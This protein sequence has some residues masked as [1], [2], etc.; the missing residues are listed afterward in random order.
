MMFDHH[1]TLRRSNR[2]MTTPM[3]GESNV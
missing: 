1:T 3:T 2:S